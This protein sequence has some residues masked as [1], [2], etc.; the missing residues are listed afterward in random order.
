MVA[1]NERFCGVRR[2]GPVVAAGLSAWLLAI[3]GWAQSVLVPAPKPPPSLAGEPGPVET[4]SAADGA[5]TGGA[6]LAGLGLSLV[7]NPFQWGPLRLRPHPTYSVTYGDGLQSQPGQAHKS[8]IQTLGLGTG[9]DWGRVWRLDYTPTLMFYSDKHF[10]DSVDHAVN[11]VGGTSYE[12]W[13]FGFSQGV[14][15]SSDPNVQTAQQTDRQSYSTSLS[16]GYQ[17]DGKNSLQLGAAQGL[18]FTSGAGLQNS[19][20]WSGNAGLNHQWEPNLGT[21][22]NVSCSYATTD[23]TSGA[24]GGSDSLSEQLNGQLTWRVLRRINLSLSGGLEIMQFLNSSQ[25]SLITPVMSASLA[26]QPFEVTTFFLSANRSVTPSLYLN[27]V[28]KGTSVSAGVSQRLLGKLMANVSTGFSTTGYQASRAGT[29]SGR[30]DDNSFFSA[31]LSTGFLK[32][33]SASLSYS[34]SRNASNNAGFG[35]NSTQIGL[36]LSYAY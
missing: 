33:G 30:K 2:Y 11:L 16:A 34:A 22:V 29:V 8:V 17:M 24:G 18:N 35:Y 26:Y 3:N 20:T 27:Q 12:D 28:S 4:G 6:S 1:S 32:R 25:S 9:I 23:A 15:F 31:G 19:Q 36:L 13:N 5:D 21:G 14:S 10:K 7:Q